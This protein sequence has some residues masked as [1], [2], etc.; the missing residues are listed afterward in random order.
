MHAAFVRSFGPPEVIEYGELP[1]P[2]PGPTDALVRME[3]SEVNYVDLYMR[4][5]RVSPGVPLPFI[6][7]R[8][9]VGTVVDTGERVWTNSLGHR[10]RQ[11]AF[12]EYAVVPRDRLYPLPP[13]VDV[14]ETAAVL[15]GAGTAH[16]GLFR[17]A[18]LRPG[19]TVFIGG[20][21]GSVGAAAVA[22]AHWAGARV[23]ASASADD[24]DTV[25]AA[26]ADVALDRRSERLG[27]EIAA[28]APDGVDVWWDTSGHHDPEATLRHLRHGGRIVIS[29]ALHATPAVPL[30]PLYT[31]DAR[32]V[33]F[34]ISNASAADLARAA[35]DINLLLA[36][37]LLPARIATTLPLARAREA[38]ELVEAGGVRGRVVIEP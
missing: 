2:T 17:E 32:I 9:L 30:G 38:H 5:G 29:A 10:G 25:R 35:A 34:A 14:R 15:H 1:V 36:R 12:A 21:A 6:I 22:M 16:L 13:G 28:A 24:L 3:A 7:G 11:G 19:E 8:D 37:G 27:Y 4:A 26:G 31:R 20:G 23:V 18:G 33:G